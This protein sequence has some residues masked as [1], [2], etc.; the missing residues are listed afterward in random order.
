[1]N[2]T[3][4]PNQNYKK[5]EQNVPYQQQLQGYRQNQNLMDK[6]K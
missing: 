3:K 5:P 6:M 4:S 2:Q 1:M